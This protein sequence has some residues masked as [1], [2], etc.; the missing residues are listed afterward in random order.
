MIMTYIKM[1]A[2]VIMLAQPAGRVPERVP[3]GNAV[4]VT[5]SPDM[6]PKPASRSAKAAARRSTRARGEDP[7]AAAQ[8]PAVKPA[9]PKSS[10]APPA[11][12]ADSQ[13]ADKAVVD[14]GIA[15]AYNAVP[16]LANAAA[17]DSSSESK[18]ADAK[19]ADT[20]TADTKPASDTRTTQQQVMDAMTVAELLTTFRAIP[21]PDQ[22]TA[23]TD[24][25][26]AIIMARPDIKSVSD[27]AGKN[28]AIDG[29]QFNGNVRTAI[30]AAGATAVQLSEDQTRAID[31]LIG[32]EVP[33]AILTLVS[34]EAAEKF[35]DVEGY[36]IFRVPLSPL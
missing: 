14:A 12:I 10:E 32:G 2:A 33:A 26:V 7:K 15:R 22:K 9:K 27:L 18:T 25:L 36:R 1:V 17:A 16:P 3:V 28:V 29:R 5:R 35:P 23:N 6:S 30:A 21:E 11:K 34:P 13:P 4:A 20:K 31:R 19:T 24:R 8:A